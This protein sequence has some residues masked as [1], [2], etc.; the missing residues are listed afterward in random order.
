LGQYQGGRGFNDTDFRVIVPE[1]GVYPFRIIYYQGGGG[2]NMEFS[3]WINGSADGVGNQALVN[4]TAHGAVAAFAAIKPGSI[5]LGSPTNQPPTTA[6]PF[7]SI[8]VSGNQVTMTW[9]TPGRLQQASSL[10]VSGSAKWA[11][12]TP[13][14]SSGTY[15]TTV[16]TGG[17]LYYRLISP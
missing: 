8:T 6:G 13:A 5:Q 12:V 11:D 2:G 9:T 4:D 15:T 16:T 14:A 10:A 7:T 17:A 3:Q 1:P